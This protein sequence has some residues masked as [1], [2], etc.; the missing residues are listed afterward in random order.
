MKADVYKTAKKNYFLFL[1]QGEPFSSLA[2]PI[3]DQVGSLQTETKSCVRQAA[4]SEGSAGK[5]NRAAS[6]R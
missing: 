6:P 1:P 5:D 4:P 3:L 2:Q